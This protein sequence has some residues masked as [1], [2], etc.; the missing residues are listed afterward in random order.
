MGRRRKANKRLPPRVYLKHGAYYFVDSDAKWHRLGDN[1]GDLYRA[2]SEWVE[3]GPVQTMDQAFDRYSLEVIP[4]KAPRTQRDNLIELVL[5]RA[6]FG[7]MDP[8]TF[9]PK[10]GYAY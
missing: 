3:E 8:G 2:Y 7:A 5:L 6:A 1:L 10:H 4:N 9:Q